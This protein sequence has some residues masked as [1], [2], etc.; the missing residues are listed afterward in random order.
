MVK[1]VIDMIV[2][3][4]NG[5]ESEGDSGHVNENSLHISALVCNKIN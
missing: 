2:N 1:T 5:Y 4:S 3:Y